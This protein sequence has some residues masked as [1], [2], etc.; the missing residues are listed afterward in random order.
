MIPSTKS[1][2]AAALLQKI[3][4]SA[5][6]LTLAA[7]SDTINWPHVFSGNEVPPAVINQPRVVETPPPDAVANKPWPRLGDVPA[8]PNNFTAAPLID[9]TKD[10]MTNDRAAAADIRQRYDNPS[11]PTPPVLQP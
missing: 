4:T 7:C 9:A 11:V 3:L 6:L 8:K 5:G 1:R 10:E 2:V